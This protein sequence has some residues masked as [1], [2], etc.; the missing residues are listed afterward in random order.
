MH[1]TSRFRHAGFRSLLLAILVSAAVIP[2]LGQAPATKRAFTPGDWYKVKTLSA[3]VMSADGKYIAVQV[4]NVIEAKNTRMNE[5]WVVASA[6]G[7]GS[8]KLGSRSSV[9]W[10]VR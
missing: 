2:A 9:A 5:I 6:P 10:W 1:S 8:E 7:G 4:T 3:P